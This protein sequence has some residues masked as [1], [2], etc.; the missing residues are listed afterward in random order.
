MIA[1]LTQAMPLAR[2]VVSTCMGVFLTAETGLLGNSSV[3]THWRWTEKLKAHH[4]ELN[5]ICEPIFVRQENYASSAGVTSGIDLS[6]SLVEEDHDRR[7]ALAVAKAL[8]LYLRR[9]GSQSQFSNSL[10]FQFLEQ[11]DKF[12]SLNAWIDLNLN[13][14][15]SV[16]VLAER[17]GMSP[18][19]FSRA[20]AKH[21]GHT[22]GR[23]VEVFRLEKAKQML[24]TT[25]IP[26]KTISAQVG[27]NDYERMRRTFI[28]HTGINPNDY[29]RR[30]GL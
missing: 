13:S 17:V 14:D 21:V 4:P 9:T 18:R 5:V 16:S 19:N 22:P 1:W 24:E 27:F 6:L 10:L 20:Y 7:L 11:S 2:R 30:F 23:A 29:R 28:R 3:T 25:D 12:E 15:L 8:V 26:I